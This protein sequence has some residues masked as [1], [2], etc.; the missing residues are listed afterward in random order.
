ME[1]AWP[2]WRKYV[3]VGV[4]FEILMLAAWK[5]IFSCSPSEQDVEFSAPLAPWLPMVSHHDNN[6]LTPDPVC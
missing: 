1:Q 3:T 4:V 5:P 6:G 2:S